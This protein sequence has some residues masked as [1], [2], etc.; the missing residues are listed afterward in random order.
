MYLTK[1]QNMLPV[2]GFQLGLHWICYLFGNIIILQ[3]NISV[4]VFVEL[5]Y[6]SK[7]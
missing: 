7:C 6:L 1:G 2:I 4:G 5:Y 3:F